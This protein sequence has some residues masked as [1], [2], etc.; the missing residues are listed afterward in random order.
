M[1]EEK[2]NEAEETTEEPHGT[3]DLE[4]KYAKLQTESRK[5]EKRAKD[6]AQAAQELAALKEAQM[7][8]TEKLTARAEQAERELEALRAVN[9]HAKDVREVASATGV[10]ADLLDYC[11][12]RDAMEAFAAKYADLKPVHA[13]PP[14]PK[15]QLVSGKPPTTSNRDAFAAMAADAF[16]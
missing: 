11:R 1:D 2:T 4:A 7:S 3:E 14:A 8:E 5:W 9:Q 13:A 10:P 6:N 12:D 15:S 16:R